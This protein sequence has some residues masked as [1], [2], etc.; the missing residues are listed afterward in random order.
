M[1][2]LQQH[3]A[4]GISIPYKLLPESLVPILHTVLK[5]KKFYFLNK[6]CVQA[7]VAISASED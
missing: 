7:N 2:D 5:F 3:V 1:P 4:S 6:F